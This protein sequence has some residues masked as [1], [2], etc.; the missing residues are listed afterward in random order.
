MASVRYVI[1]VVTGIMLLLSTIAYLLLSMWIIP[2][3]VEQ[4]KKEMAIEYTGYSY[5]ALTTIL[6]AETIVNLII[7]RE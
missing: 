6:T 2:T 7:F 1:T 3:Y 5:Y 4:A